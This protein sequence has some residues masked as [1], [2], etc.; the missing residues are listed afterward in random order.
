MYPLKKLV[1]FFKISMWN[2]KWNTAKILLYFLLTSSLF[3]S[4]KELGFS[5]VSIVCRTDIKKMI[6]F[7]FLEEMER[8]G[9]VL[10]ILFR[11]LA[12]S[13]NFGLCHLLIQSEIK[14]SL[15]SESIFT[16]LFQSTK[17]VQTHHP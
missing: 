12:I 16:N 3:T 7:T 5:H 2:K 15:I 11:P 10:E 9:I 17:K 1:F 6:S 13:S 14:G 4:K 8:L